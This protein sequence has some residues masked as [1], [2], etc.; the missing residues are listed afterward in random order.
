M[1]Y[2]T[3]IK[4]VSGE[5][6]VD[7]RGTL[8]RFI[9]YLPVQAGDK[10]FTDGKFI[11]GNAKV[12]GYSVVDDENIA[13]PVLA[14]ESNQTNEEMRGYFTNDGRY[15]NFTI[16]QDDWIINSKNIFKHGNAEIDGQKII[17]IEFSEDGDLWTVTDGEYRDCK[18]ITFDNHMYT[19]DR[20]K[21]VNEPDDDDHEIENYEDL[22]DLGLLYTYCTY[23]RVNSHIGAEITLGASN[24]S[25]NNPVTIYKGEE[26]ITKINLVFYANTA[27]EKSLENRDKIMAKSTNP[28]TSGAVNFIK[29]PNPPESF[30]ASTC[31]RVLSFRINKKGDWDA[32]IMASAYG[33][34]F[35]YLVLNASVILTTFNAAY[36]GSREFSKRLERCKENIERSLFRE[37]TYSFLEVE[38]YPE[39][40]GTVKDPETGEY[41]EEYKLCIQNAIEYYIPLV[42]FKQYEWYIVAF[43][44]S[45][46]FHVHNGEIVTTMQVRNLIGNLVWPWR[47]WDESHGYHAMIING[48]EYKLSDTTFVNDSTPDVLEEWQFPIDDDFYLLGK[49]AFITGILNIKTGNVLS[50]PTNLAY[51][52]VTDKAPNPFE[53]DE[54][55]TANILEME[56]KFSFYG[57]ETVRDEKAVNV[58]RLVNR[59][60]A[61][62]FNCDFDL[63]RSYYYPVATNGTAIINNR[64]DQFPDERLDAPNL[65]AYR[66]VDGF[67]D[68]KVKYGIDSESRD[69]LF[70]YNPTIAKLSGGKYL[71][72]LHDENLWLRNFGKWKELADYLKNFRLKE[73]KDIREAKT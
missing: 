44:A 64:Y 70:R 40:Q 56:E 6:A 65:K 61:Y 67:F 26:E 59:T 17:E 31:A 16:N 36:G 63:P 22:S 57:I 18:T 42:R 72:G 53:I 34:C 35:P 20:T 14:A 9:G 41:T 10:I 39:F 2:A 52:R 46:L 3:E 4:E 15:K 23:L 55:G 29:Q 5:H 13:I 32:I 71:F 37:S 47:D 7:T 27:K 24:D 66:F 60:L 30:V 45:M 69:G 1:F 49:G 21:D 11:F 25:I 50:A 38:K 73:L 58:A 12:K 28:Y 48:R 51:W 33:Y 68:S 54:Y 19:I 8:L 62:V 43:G